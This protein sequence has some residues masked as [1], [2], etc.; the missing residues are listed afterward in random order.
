MNVGRMYVDITSNL[1]MLWRNKGALFWM[2]AFPILLMVIFGSIF[3]Q[4]G[5]TTLRLYVLDEDRS[6]L[7]TTFVGALNST[8]AFEMRYLDPGVDVEKEIQDQEIRRL[9]IIPEGFNA[10]FAE[11][12]TATMTLRLDESDQ[13]TSAATSQIVR[14]VVY[15]FNLAYS[16]SSKELAI[17]ETGLT[18]D[19]QFEYIDFFLPGIIGMT[20]MTSGVYGAIAVNTRYRKNGILRK[21][22]TTPMTKA[23]WV[24]SKVVYQIFVAFISMGALV[25]VAVLV[26]GVKV[27]FNPLVIL[28]VVTGSMTFSGLGMIVARF[29]KDEE[30]AESAGGAINFPMM[31][32]SGIFF[33]LEMMPSYLQAVGKV[34]PL[35]YV[36]EGLRDAMIYNDMSA[37]LVSAA[38]IFVLGVVIVAIGSVVSAWTDE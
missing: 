32:L 7:S 13:Q 6:V 9:L 10:T 21:V 5:D 37:A 31:F 16:N 38:I 35:Y 28:L 18:L 2:M 24:I 36:G 1:R 30:A 25:A 27:H 17:Q 3:A 22:A 8:G 19:E 15:E 12:G 33:P 11:T 4:T 29:V 14:A 23:E 20:I 34:M 26:Y